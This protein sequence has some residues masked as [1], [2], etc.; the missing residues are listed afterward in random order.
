MLLN[1]LSFYFT[2]V[3]LVADSEG[4]VE[5]KAEHNYRHPTTYDECLE[6]LFNRP[7]LWP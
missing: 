2:I 6:L 7:G 1:R 4:S 5:E 3:M